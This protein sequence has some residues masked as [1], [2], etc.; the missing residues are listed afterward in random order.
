MFLSSAKGV[1][2][3]LKA[4]DLRSLNST[5]FVGKVKYFLGRSLSLSWQ[6]VSDMELWCG[7][8]GIAISC[9]YCSFTPWLRRQ[10]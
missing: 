2:D 5:G 1:L 9:V 6:Q 10:R 7:S 8:V 4:S 3:G